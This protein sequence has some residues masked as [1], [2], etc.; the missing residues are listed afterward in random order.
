MSCNPLDLGGCVSDAVG[1]GIDKLADTFREG[2]D[3]AMKTLTTSWLKAPSPDLTSAKSPVTWMQSNLSYFVLA[4]VLLS[5]LIAA[6]KM[7]T[8]GDFDHLGDLGQQLAKVLIVGG[9]AASVTATAV[10]IGD[11]FSSWI[12]DQAKVD[13]S[14]LVVLSAQLNPSIVILL[15][16]VVILAQIIQLGLMLIRNGMIILL[17]GALP[18]TAANSSTATGRQTWQKSLAWLIAFVLYK[19]VAALIYAAC[20][21]MASRDQ[22]IATQISGIFMMLLAI[23][24][25]PALMRFLVPATAAMGN[26]SGGSMAAGMIGAAV[27]TGAVMATGGAGAAAGGAGFSG[28]ASMTAGNAG[29]AATGATTTGAP[30]GSGGQGP[31]GQAAQTVQGGDGGSTNDS[32]GSSGTGDTGGRTSGGSGWSTGMN[33]ASQGVNLGKSASNAGDEAVGEQQ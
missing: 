5:V 24:A 12:L 29:G 26:A 8:S 32:G 4:S 28:G 15:A 3:W 20:F 21:K 11:L 31:G 18:L 13:F 27:A 2:A 22:D 25:L 7:A 9:A 17:V 30:G 1:S 23:F 6:Y 16:V 33:A 19:P 10:G 14:G